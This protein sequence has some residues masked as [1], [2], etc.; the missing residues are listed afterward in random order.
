[1]GLIDNVLGKLYKKRAND[2]VAYWL[3]AGQVPD[4]LGREPIRAGTDYLR[5]DLRA[6]EVVY[7]QKGL[8]KFYGIVN[9]V[10]ALTHLGE[11]TA[12]FHAV[13][14]PPDLKDV[15]AADLERFISFNRPL[16]GPV[17]YRG[18]DVDIQVGLFSVASASLLDPYLGLLE[19]IGNK[20]SVEFINLALPYAGLLTT[21]IALLTGSSNT[22]SLEVGVWTNLTDLRSGWLLIMRADRAKF[23]LK[24]LKAL[25]VEGDDAKLMEGEQ[26]IKEYP[27]VILRVSGSSRR[28]DFAKIPELKGQHDLYREAL[29]S[30]DA[31]KAH[32]A[33]QSFRRYL[34]TC[35]DLLKTDATRIYG[36][37]TN[38]FQDL[39]GRA[40]TTV[41]TVAGSG[42]KTKAA[43]KT[44]SL[45]DYH[46]YD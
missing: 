21:G 19:E 4:R 9:S 17:P 46:I 38:D 40:Q 31:E 30:N 1:V 11:G 24:R 29:R 15:D 10:V 2:F 18:G 20:C 33:L 37:A 32:E 22:K 28:D 16:A 35:P 34:F 25:A 42:K 23:P 36:E 6:L 12:Q 14:A 13:I 39:Y 45:S 41:A 44:R 26:Q 27:Y 5:I 43:P 3:E 7:V 8:T